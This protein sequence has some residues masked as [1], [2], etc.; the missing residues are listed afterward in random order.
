MIFVKFLLSKGAEWITAEG[1]VDSSS[2]ELFYSFYNYWEVCF[3]I[4]F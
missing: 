2:L 4:Y 3:Y 1:F